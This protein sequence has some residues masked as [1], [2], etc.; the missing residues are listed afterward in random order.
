[1]ENIHGSAQKWHIV[2]DWD[3][4][5]P[6]MYNLWGSMMKNIKNPKKCKLRNQSDKCITGWGFSYDIIMTSHM[7]WCYF[8]DSPLQSC[9]QNQMI[10]FLCESMEKHHGSSQIIHSW[11]E[12]LLKYVT[13]GRIHADFKLIRTK[14][15]K[16]V[17]NFGFT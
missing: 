14:S 4:L 3:F 2:V 6:T 5:F 8:G 17:P 12:R 13:F 15:Q 10:W 1:M 16:L 7:M 11:K 9:K